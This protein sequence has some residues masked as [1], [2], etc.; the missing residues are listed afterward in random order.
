MPRQINWEQ[1][2]QYWSKTGDSAAKIALKFNVSKRAIAERIAQW[3]ANPVSHKTPTPA[4]VFANPNTVK[5]DLDVVD[6]AIGRLSTVILSTN[7][8][9]VLGGIATALVRLI[10]FRQQLQP[11]TAAQLAEAAI[12]AGISPQDFIRELDDRWR[13]QA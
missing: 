1:I 3:K 10:Q 2:Y 7:D 8:E 13:Q 11:P 9:R 5:N 12:S 4:P 6:G